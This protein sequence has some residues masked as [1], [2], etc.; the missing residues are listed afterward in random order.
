MIFDPKKL[1]TVATGVVNPQAGKKKKIGGASTESFYPPNQCARAAAISKSGHLAIG[2]NTG[3]VHIFEAKDLNKKIKSLADAKEWIE[4]IAYSPNDK[5][6][7]VGSHDNKIY[8]YEVFYLLFLLLFHIKNVILFYKAKGYSLVS[9]CTSHNSFITSLDWSED[10]ENLQSICG[11]YELLF[12][13]AQ[14][15]KQLK[16]DNISLIF[17]FIKLFYY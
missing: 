11:A 1:K 9:Q 8:I 4:A 5:F 15:G 14:N 17:Y 2:V 16:S 3:E 6:L 12:H 10:G 13:H 7:A